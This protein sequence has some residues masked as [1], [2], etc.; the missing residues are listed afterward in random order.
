LD[1]DL[2]AAEL[3]KAYT[4]INE[5]QDRRFKRMGAAMAKPLNPEYFEKLYQSLRDK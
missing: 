4:K 1:L 2:V 5:R 3:A